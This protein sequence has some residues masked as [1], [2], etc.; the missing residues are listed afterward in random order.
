MKKRLSLSL[1]FLIFVTACGGVAQRRGRS[2]RAPSAM[3][4]E[5]ASPT[6]ASREAS[7]AMTASVDS[8]PHDPKAHIAKLF[9]EIGT[10]RQRLNLPF[11][12]MADDVSEAHTASAPRS[13]DVAA[14]TEPANSVCK[15][16]CTVKAS[17]CRNSAKICELADGLDD[18]W[19]DEKCDSGKV[20]CREATTQCDECS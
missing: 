9:N 16:T 13:A 2:A 6:E 12:P 7:P 19:A 4:S 20:S 15:E 11:E 8:Y 17:I 3:E 14:G 10:G 1:C 18:A 5:S